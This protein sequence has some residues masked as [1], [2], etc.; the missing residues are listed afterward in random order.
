M[1]DWRIRVNGDAAVTVECEPRIDAVINEWAVALANAIRAAR[2]PGV[3]DVVPSYS[4]V[5]VYFNPLHTD[6]DRLWAALEEAAA[7]P[8]AVARAPREVVV[9]VRYG[10]EAGPDL[11][12][13]AAYAGCPPDEVVRRHTAPRYRVYMVGFLPGFPYLGT[14]DARIAMPRR[15]NPRL[16]VPAASVG[17]AGSQTGIYPTTAPGGWRLIGLAAVDTFDARREPP[18]LF[19]PG[20]TVRFR[21]MSTETGQ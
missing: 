7:A 4:A 2:Y 21:A 11:D 3:R 18:S 20:D 8:V 17:I 10:G 6:L 19:R 13:V 1:P 15:S 12:E 9:P 16:A 5:T 14:V